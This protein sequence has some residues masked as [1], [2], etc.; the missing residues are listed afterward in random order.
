MSLRQFD[1]K[2]FEMILAGYRIEGYDLEFFSVETDFNR[3]S[4]VQGIDGDA[5]RVRNK[6]RSGTITIRLLQSSPSNNFMSYTSIIDEL[7]GVGVLPFVAK[8]R[9][10]GGSTIV[11]PS[12]FITKIPDPTFGVTHQAREWRLRSDNIFIYLAGLSPD[13]GNSGTTLEQLWNSV[14]PFSDG[15]PVRNPDIP[16]F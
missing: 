7:S 14:N 5:A 4:L 13:G 1:P 11:A 6:L 9:G 8:E 3:Y 16:G 12:C 15:I 2:N 10:F